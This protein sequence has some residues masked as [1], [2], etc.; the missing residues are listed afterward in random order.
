MPQ[1]TVAVIGRPR[2]G[3]RMFRD[4]A[5]PVSMSTDRA[6]LR[7][8]RDHYSQDLSRC[9]KTP[10]SARVHH[11]GI[12]AVMRSERGELLADVAA[13]LLAGGVDVI[14]VTFT[15][16]RAHRV[17]EQV[18]D[19]LEGKILLGAGTVLDTE[20]AR[21]AILSGAQFIVSPTV[22]VDVIRLCHRYSKL[23]MPGAFT[24]TEVLSAW[25]QGAD[26]VKIFPS[27]VSGPA[28]LTAL[29]GPLP[30]VRMMPTGGVNLETAAPFLHAGAYA[31]GIGGSLVDSK[32]VA[33]GD[34]PA[35]ERPRPPVC[36]GCAAGPGAVR[37]RV[38][39]GLDRPAC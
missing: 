1:G 4:G 39:A 3:C 24:P 19:R 23:A 35:I 27:D 14:E 5:F 7:G 28:Y 16:P 36:R 29:R 15:V 17:I 12:V 26:I 21:I 8:H 38:P 20:T 6:G 2:V 33:A 32:A 13:A 18:A 34:L 10:I 31:L 22:N 37:R 9:P 25:E 11:A 30:Q